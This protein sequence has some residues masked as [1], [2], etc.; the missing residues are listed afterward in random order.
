MT[1]P[2]LVLQA[3][4]PALSKARL[5]VATCLIH[6][7]Y[8]IMGPPGDSPKKQVAGSGCEVRGEGRLSRAGIMTNHR[9]N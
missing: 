8:L 9:G 4:T 2:S 7:I 6:I 3:L 5:S 1:T